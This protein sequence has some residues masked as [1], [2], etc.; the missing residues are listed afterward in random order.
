MAEDETPK[1]R[2]RRKKIKP[3]DTLGFVRIFLAMTSKIPVP[4]YEDMCT[5]TQVNSH[6]MPYL[7][8]HFIGAFENMFYIA[9]EDA[10]RTIIQCAELVCGLKVNNKVVPRG[11]F[12]MRTAF[13]NFLDEHPNAVP[14][15]T[16]PSAFD[17]AYVA[18]VLIT[19]V[20]LCWV[21]YRANDW[22]KKA[23]HEYYEEE[24]PKVYPGQEYAII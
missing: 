1:K 22:A 12:F 16:P 20:Y 6:G 21:K 14:S 7:E 8:E 15:D 17:P 2:S 5:I 18:S 3:E 4:A 13:Q 24:C 9:Q 19:D 10:I 11:V 23:G